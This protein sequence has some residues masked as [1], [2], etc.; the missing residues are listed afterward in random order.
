MGMATNPMAK[1]IDHVRRTVLRRDGARPSD[2]QLLAG[3]VSRRDEAAFEAIVRRHGPMVMGVCRRLLHNRHDAEDAFQATFLVLVRKAGSIASRELLGNW[4]YGVAYNTAR[5]AQAVYARR[6]A[7]E[8]Q[9]TDTPEPEAA[10]QDSRNVQLLLDQE[11]NRLPE[12]YRI[13]IVLC[14]LQGMSHKEAARQLRCPQGTV[15]GRLSRA[16]VMLAKRL[17]RRG[18]E[19]P[20]G[21]LMVILS[22]AGASASVTSSMV[23]STVRAAKQFAAGQAAA[24]GIVSAKVAA[25]AEG[26]LKNML[27][28]KLRIGAGIAMVLTAVS[29]G[30][31]G[32]V[33]A[34]VNAE[35]AAVRKVVVPPISR[36][37][38]AADKPATAQADAKKGRIFVTA[39]VRENDTL[40]NQ[41]IAID[42][43]TGKWTKIADNGGRPRISPDGRTALLGRSEG[44]WNCDTKGGNNPGQ[45]SDKGYYAVWSPDGKQIIVSGGKQEEGKWQV[46][47]WLM[48]P[49]GSKPTRLPVHEED[50]VKDWS[51]DGKWLLTV[52][53]RDRIRINRT[54]YIL[55]GYQVYLMQPDGQNQRRLTK[56]G[57][58]LDPRFS[59]DGKRILYNYVH[60]ERDEGGWWIMDADGK[61]ARE[62]FR[63]EGLTSSDGAC[64]SPDGKHLA[65]V[66][67]DWSVDENGQKVLRRA[68]EDAN[69]RIE[70]TDADGKNRRQLNL[71]N[72]KPL[73]LSDPDWR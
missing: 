72:L 14:D 32:L 49:D 7:R 24:A 71:D 53:D 61:N 45:I 54:R 59:P 40:V 2:G 52:S 22:E 16:R 3:F 17:A 35:Q 51:P 20:A 23:A 19:L 70:I 57:V 1:V 41:L 63:R 30:A 69:Y 47:N 21:L 13:P 64:W 15:S 44:V 18:L 42:P 6:Q 62:V 4:L 67:F 10:P 65:V 31:L 60:P 25:L 56:D 29:L 8:T 28:S 48:N 68:D 9:V 43:E 36:G 50:H 39:S 46:E 34:S 55:Y 58:N 38:P 12:K 26:V 73:Y 11:L 5:K 33:S 37:A 66:L 27:L